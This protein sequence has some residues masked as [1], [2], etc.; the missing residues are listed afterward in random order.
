LRVWTAFV[1]I[2]GGPQCHFADRNCPE[3]PSGDGSR[4]TR[5]RADVSSA[6]RG[7]TEG[8]RRWKALAAAIA[9]RHK[10][11]IGSDPAG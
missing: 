4:S 2:G 1:A 8:I 6:A 10:V 11:R 3:R 5:I 7:T 9:R